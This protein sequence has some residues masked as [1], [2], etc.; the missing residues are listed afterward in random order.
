MFIRISYVIYLIKFDNVDSSFFFFFF[1]LGGRG[2]M[3]H[4]IWASHH[5]FLEKPMLMNFNFFYIVYS[6]NPVFLF[7]FFF[8]SKLHLVSFL[9]KDKRKIKK[10]F[11]FYNIAFF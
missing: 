6:K 5:S 10:L 8:S 4:N 7:S 2:I 11:S 1:E 3:I 9:E